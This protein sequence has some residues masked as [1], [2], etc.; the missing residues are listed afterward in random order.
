MG[1]AGSIPAKNIVK[2]LQTEELF[3]LRCISRCIAIKEVI[4]KLGKMRKAEIVSFMHKEQAY[5]ET[6]PREVIEFKYAKSLQI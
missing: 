6:A 4:D 3:Y 1:I 5:V 2:I